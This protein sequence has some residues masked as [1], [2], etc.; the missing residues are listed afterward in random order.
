MIDDQP[1]AGRS[2]VEPRLPAVRVGFGA[3]CTSDKDG[4]G[5]GKP[6]KNA[7]PGRGSGVRF[8][9]AEGLRVGDDEVIVGDVGFDGVDHAARGEL[10][11][12]DAMD[13]EP[14]ADVPDDACPGCTSSCASAMASRT[15]LP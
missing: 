11:R 15:S 5:R 9:D 3:G 1:A 2:A 6:S 12:L 13:P 8:L 14:G 10:G 4:V 7:G